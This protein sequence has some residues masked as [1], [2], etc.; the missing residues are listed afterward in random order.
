[1]RQKKPVKKRVKQLIY[2]FSQWLARQLLKLFFGCRY[3]Y[4]E[5][6]PTE[7]PLI[8]AS[9]HSSYLDPPSVGAGIAR[10]IHFL[11]KRE[12]F[13]NP[14]FGALIR[15]YHAVPIRRAGMD[16]EGLA[17]IREILDGG[18]AVILFPEGTRQRGG[19]LG[20]PRFGVGKLAQETRASI[21]PVYA[22]GTADLRAAFLRRRPMRITYGRL[23]LPG[24]YED[25]ELN[26]RGQLA[27]SGLVMERI[28]ELKDKLETA[29]NLQ[30]RPEK[31][32]NGELK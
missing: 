29:G 9:N 18:G 17:R 32:E 21:L 4:E 20:K 26:P 22:R 30:D 28:A 16:W 2:R 31:R 7:G 3:C 25:F 5:P 6:I 24:Q 19:S 15:F 23:I 27:I 12:L 8:I 14:F 11:A 13:K 1:M 10:E